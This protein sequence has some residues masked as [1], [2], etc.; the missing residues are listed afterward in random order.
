VKTLLADHDSHVLEMLDIDENSALHLACANDNVDI[1]K[2]LLDANADVTV[3]NRQGIT[4]LDVAIDWELSDVAIALVQHKRY[5]EFE[6]VVDSLLCF[7]I[8]CVDSL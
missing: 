3:R 7:E 5:Q 8:V 6:F 1:V 2:E 4:C